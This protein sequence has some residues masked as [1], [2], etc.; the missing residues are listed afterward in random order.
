VLKPVQMSQISASDSLTLIQAKTNDG[1]LNK[2]T[3]I[4]LGQN[5]PK[6]TTLTDCLPVSCCVSFDIILNTNVNTI[7]SSL[8]NMQIAFFD[9]NKLALLAG[10]V[11]KK[12]KEDF[13]LKIS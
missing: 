12:K 8:N 6:T 7:A 1:S 9:S 5:L 2:A 4:G 3:A 13:C 10:K 11:Y